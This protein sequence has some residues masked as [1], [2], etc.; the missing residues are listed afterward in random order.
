MPGMFHYTDKVGWNAVRSQP[1]WRFKV[2]QP[3][4]P[5]RPCGTYFTDIEPT[6]ANLRTLYKRIR[7]PKTK[8]EYVFWFEGDYGLIQLNAGRGRDRRIWFSPL[9]YDVAEARQR[10]AGSTD[11][12]EEHFK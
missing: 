11:D 2:N 7:V 3:H 1:V 10:Y 9:D 6:P 12:I 4:D 8:Q 5:N